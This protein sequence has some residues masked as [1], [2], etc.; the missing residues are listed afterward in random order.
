MN[1]LDP[2]KEKYYNYYMTLA[3]ETARNSTALRKKV[4]AIIVLPNGLIAHG[5]NGTASTLDN[6]CEETIIIGTNKFIH[7]TKP[8][9]IHAERNALDKLSRAGISPKDGIL[10][11]TT[12]PCLECA[13][14]VHGVGI[15]KVIYVN[16]YKCDSGINYLKSL[17][18]TVEQY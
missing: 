11:V 18:V 15:K 7:K 2:L 12:A 16:K 14:S 17:N 10:F 6:M 5:W 9:V 8:E 13:K 3:L 1:K 4:G